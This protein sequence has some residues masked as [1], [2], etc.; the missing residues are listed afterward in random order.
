MK[1]ETSTMRSAITW[2][3]LLMACAAYSFAQTPS[4]PPS[5]GTQNAINGINSYPG[6][7][8]VRYEPD[9]EPNDRR[10][11]LFLSDW[12]GSMPLARHGS[13]GLRDF[14]TPGANFA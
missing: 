7:S 8:L 4:P 3:V 13:L 12:H 5:S 6:P 1:K 10:I 11:D 14:L 2:S 9:R